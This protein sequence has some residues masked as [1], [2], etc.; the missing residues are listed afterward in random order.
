MPVQEKPEYEMEYFPTI[1]DINEPRKVIP[2]LTY[3]KPCLSLGTAYIHA[4]PI[5]RS[6]KVFTMWNQDGYMSGS[7]GDYL[8]VRA[9]DH[10]DVYIIQKDIFQQSYE[11]I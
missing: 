9:D 6:T 4:V 10:N 7:P 8:A 3:A 5:Q 2:L 1:I 11:A